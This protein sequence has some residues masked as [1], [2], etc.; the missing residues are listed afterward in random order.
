MFSMILSNPYDR[1]ITATKVVDIHPLKIT[2]TTFM[3]W[4]VENI[5]DFSIYFMRD[6]F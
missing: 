5:H 2:T 3:L 4:I 6:I 1:V